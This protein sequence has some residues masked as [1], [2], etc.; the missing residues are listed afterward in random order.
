M[1]RISL[2]ILFTIVFSLGAFAQMIKIGLYAD[3][4][5]KSVVVY[6]TNG[7]YLI[8]AENET[9]GEFKKGD[10]LFVRLNNGMLD[11]YN[12]NR[13]FGAF[14]SLE[15]QSL[16]LNG[17]YRTRP[18]APA[19][20]SRSYDDDLFLE[21]EDEYMNIINHVDY[22]KYIAGVLE[23]EMGP[24]ST[25]ELYK[26]HALLSRTYMLENFNKHAEEGFSLCDGVH[27]QAYHGRSV[28]NPIIPEAVF[29]TSGEVVA[30]YHYKLITAVYHSN[31]GGET[32]R[33]SDVWLE[34]T[35]YLQA[36]ID[37]YSL[38]ESHA[39]WYD[40]IYYDD[41]KNYLL[42]N[43][44]KAVEKLPEEL[45]YIQQRHRKKHFILDQDSLLMTKIRED[46]GFKSTFFNM[47]PEVGNR[48]VI[49]GKGYGHGVGL[50]QEGAARMA[51]MDFNYMD[52]IKF[53]FF[54]VRIM[55]YEDLPQSSLPDFGQ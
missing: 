3:E 37:P 8:R 47:F 22:D 19:L 33:A 14:E 21:S 32:Q 18:V 26:A 4:I 5:V 46:W 55:H 40:T 53:Y 42:D 1:K 48:I 15:L 36:V 20:D 38:H 6:C 54:N 43:G 31:S 13:V 24:N 17:T 34:D 52:I 35:E 44:M 29:E 39:K 2:F 25:I 10:I 11:L 50:S 27:C 9:V 45:L 49:W 41:W 28:Y 30:D 7:E 23:S 16:S 12:S 51:E